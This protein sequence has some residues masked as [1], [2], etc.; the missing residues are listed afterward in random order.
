WIVPASLS[1]FSK[2]ERNYFS[3]L[4][5]KE[6][7][8]LSPLNYFFIDQVLFSALL[9]KEGL[10][11][12]VKVLS[13]NYNFP[14]ELMQQE[15]EKATIIHHQ[16]YCKMKGTSGVLLPDSIKQLIDQSLS[17]KYKASRWLKTREI[18]SYQLYK[19][20]LLSK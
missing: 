20:S 18:L 12:Q 16:D 9:A 8:Q 15:V 10:N 4:S 7:L 6:V 14:L 13:K 17:H 11:P 5:K 3:I 1:F 2:L 19:I